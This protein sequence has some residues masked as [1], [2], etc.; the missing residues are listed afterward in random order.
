MGFSN[1]RCIYCGLAGPRTHNREVVH[2]E[3]AQ[4]GATGAAA[5]A[6]LR[7]LAGNALLLPIK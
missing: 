4:K 1:L 5:G 6:E 2:V 3:D 7:H